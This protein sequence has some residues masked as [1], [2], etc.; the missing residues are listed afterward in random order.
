M[1]SSLFGSDLVAPRGEIVQL[2]EERARVCAWITAHGIRVLR[3]HAQH[4]LDEELVALALLLNSRGKPRSKLLA[5][6][7]CEWRRPAFRVPPSWSM[8]S[9]RINPALLQPCKGG[10]DLRWLHVPYLLSAHEGLEGGPQHV[11]VLWF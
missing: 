3:L 2:L 1:A 10:V 5:P 6:F 4:E 7:G 9:C 8:P 11:P